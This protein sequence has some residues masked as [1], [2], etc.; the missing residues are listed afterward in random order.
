MALEIGVKRT[1]RRPIAKNCRFCGKFME[2]WWAEAG[3]VEKKFDCMGYPLVP[4]FYCQDCNE[5]DNEITD[6]RDYEW[7][8]YEETIDFEE[9]KKELD[10]REF[11]LLL[12]DYHRMRQRFQNRPY[13]AIPHLA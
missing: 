7:L 8:L 2:L 3:A 5:S 6:P 10:P 4:I 13:L 12:L 1:K 11:F 9:A